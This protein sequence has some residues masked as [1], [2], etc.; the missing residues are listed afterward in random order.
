MTEP[1]DAALV[2]LTRTG[3]RETYG[4]LV[5]RCQGRVY[6]LAYSL[7]DDSP[8]PQDIAGSRVCS[9]SEAGRFINGCLLLFGQHHQVP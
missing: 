2:R 9:C 5:A 1:T 4:E 7:V 8:E 6:G 3:N